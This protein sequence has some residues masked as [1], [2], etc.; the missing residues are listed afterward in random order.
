MFDF[1][2]GFFQVVR[3]IIFSD[4][5]WGLDS[6]IYKYRVIISRIFKLLELKVILKEVMELA[7]KY[8]FEKYVFYSGLLGV[9]DLQSELGYIF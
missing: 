8:L 2:I 1:S 4:G 5:E 7:K 9:G 3:F 6:S